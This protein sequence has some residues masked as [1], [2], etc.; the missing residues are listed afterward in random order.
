M[1]PAI[2]RFAFGI[3]VVA[4]GAAAFAIA[5]RAGLSFVYRALLSGHDVLDAFRAQPRLVR[6]ALPV[7]GGLLVGMVARAGAKGG[8]VGEVMEAVV[9]GRTH[10]DLGRTSS[11]ALGSWLAIASGGSIG[12]EGPLIQFGGALGSAIAR[13]MR[14]P[15]TSTRALIAAGTA[16]GFASAY[17]TPFAAVLFVLEIVTGVVVLEAIAPVMIATVIAT[18]LTQ[19]VVGGGPIYGLRA[20]TM[21]SSTELLAS[22]TELFLHALLGIVAALVGQGFMRC[23]ALGERAFERTGVSQPFRAMLGGL[24]VG[25][26]A[27]ELPEITGN[28]YEPLNMLL[29]GHFA[30]SLVCVLVFAKVLATTASVASGSPGGVFTP[31]LF[32]GGAVGVLFGHV[33]SVLH[34][35]GSEGAFALVGMAAVSAATTHAPMMAAVLV[36]E[37]SG[38]YAI[39]LPLVL[40]TAVATMVSRR[41][42]PDS[43]YAAELRRKGV[44]WTLTYDGRHTVSPARHGQG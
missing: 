10:L 28:G 24:V 41:L 26:L 38:D 9:L 1:K 14:L 2:A 33:A 36:F 39:A 18:A 16:A 25:L 11:K 22:S 4:I 7:A 44:T 15:D 31:S 20:F 5:F 43:L 6:V 37:I 29:D 32:L 23:L 34:L 30:I 42:S 35:P 40:A 12:R 19:H 27:I 13:V 3:V 17:N 21:V 8:G